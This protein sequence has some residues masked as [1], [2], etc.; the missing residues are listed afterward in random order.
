[1][2]EPENGVLEHSALFRFIPESRRG[3][4]SEL[5]KPAKYNFGDLIVR[6]GEEA[7]AFFI[8]T[9]GRAR[10]VKM[11]DDGRELSLNMLR[12][13]AE[14]GESA[15]LSGGVR[16]AS[17][18]CSSAVEVL[19]LD[20]PVFL[21]L[22]KDFPEFQDYLQL[23][24]RWRSVHGFLYE[25]SNFGRLPAP[26]LHALV[27]E[28]KPAT[29]KKGEAILKE[30][31]PAGSMYIIEQGRVHIY[32]GPDGHAKSRAFL[33]EGDF[34]GELSV[35]TGAPRAATAR[36]VTDCRLL[37]LAPPSVNKL[38][39]EF[40]EFARLMEERRAQYQ[41]E[42]QAQVPLDFSLEELPAE[43]GTT[44][45]VELEPEP[46]A[47]QKGQPGEPG[48]FESDDGH[49]KKRKG[50]I[51]SIPL[52]QQ[53]DE[54]DCGAASL[55]MICRHFG[56]KV[57]LAR[58]RQ[59][60][61]TSHDGT[62]LKALSH[63]ATELGL[64]AR[65]LKVSHRHLPEMPVPAI[66]HWQG[67]HWMVLLD[68]GDRNVR[69]AD[70]ATGIRKIPRAEF[71][72]K[73]S[74]Y[75]ALF[76]YTPEFEKAPEGRAPLA[77]VWPFFGK[78]RVV[79]CQAFVLALIASALQL[80]FPIFTQ[81]VVDRV[82]VEQDVNLLKLAVI[83]LIVAGLFMLGSSIVQQYLLSYVTV[84]VDT[85]ILD[86]LMRQLLALPMSYFN[87]RR[88][89]DIQRRLDG[90]RQVRQFMVQHGIGAMLA[91]VQIAGCF[92]LMGLYSLTLLGVFL[93]TLPFYA[94]LMLF[95]VKVI[96]PLFADL[97]EGHGKYSSHQIDAI[98]GIEAV[99]AAAAESVF[100]DGMLNQFLLLS[101]KRFEGSFIAMSYDSAVQTISL[102]ST[103][104][105]LWVGAGM[106]LKGQITVG[107]FVAFNALLAMAYAAVFR[108]LGVWDELQM[109]V[110]LLNRLGDIFE[111]E[112]EQGR[113]R[114]RLKPVPTLE[115]HLE[116][117]NVGFRY[118]GP[119]APAI[120][121]G[122]E[123]EVGAG[124][125]VAIVGRSG[126]GKTT[127]IKLLAGLM[128]PTQGAILF[129]HVDLKTLNYRDVRRKIGL[130][131][132]E[133]WLFSD[134]ILNNICFGDPE[135]DLERAM[136][137]A[138]LANAH[139]FIARL[140]LGYETQIGETGLALSGGQRQRICIARAV[141]H[142]PPLLIFDEAT[143]ALDSES[144]RAIQENLARLMSGRTSLVIAHRLST[145]RE[146]DMIVVLEKGKVAEVG[147]HDDLMA[148]R[149]LYFYLSS[150]QLGL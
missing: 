88:T 144:E 1:M 135:P 109:I 130:V 70:P 85:A 32:S 120:L 74:G 108:T 71:E 79:L 28:L 14:F 137:A 45:K 98:K 97:E 12:P 146:A 39:T 81:V 128:E 16:S 23:T 26:A 67:N 57:S 21:G 69:V 124:K 131:L 91:L 116:L 133:N 148:R 36:A 100:R 142:D 126:S 123:L 89:G 4:L 35:L 3:R 61:H 8:L 22:L 129:D 10:V 75:S 51:M 125:M 84:N 62:S 86:F 87:S 17:V 122:I 127:L 65:A 134:T 119:E 64:A 60:C 46:A 95:S 24:M 53:I 94:G 117:R 5:F 136:R 37:S 33:R 40:P 150:Q 96:R 76:D 106:V 18:R 114:S 77:W 82:I 103:A 110:V 25:Y 138:Q 11:S 90:A 30:G 132:Q 99:K 2:N 112:P 47:A 44:N 7:D 118:G 59:L 104:L 115:G 50:R 13:G 52:V 43:A 80:L 15:L 6:Q 111:Q 48:V 55:A 19:R 20:R 72:Q 49:F 147:R 145:I 63:A 42:K 143:S 101:R 34:F 38:N 54:M 149:G 102:L 56:R 27:E 58:I 9:S 29:F 78:H 107:G 83:G 41:G 93:L 66:V 141:Y 31:E 105:F 68:V 140:P 92:V 113:D 121:E 139:D 73:W